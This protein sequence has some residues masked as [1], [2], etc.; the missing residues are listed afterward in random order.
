LVNPLPHDGWTESR[1]GRTRS[2]GHEH[3]EFDD[4]S[5]IRQYD[6]SISAYK[7]TPEEPRI[8]TDEE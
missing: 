2:H 1:A 4:N 5:L 3:W 6:A 7:A 8:A